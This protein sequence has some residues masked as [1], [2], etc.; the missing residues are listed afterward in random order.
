MSQPTLQE[1]SR[2]MST[3]SPDPQDLS[4][5]GRVLVV[6]Q[7]P[8][9][10]APWMDHLREPA[11][12][13]TIVPPDRLFQAG[14]T[15]GQ[16]CMLIEPPWDPAA[17]ER[18]L[19]GAQD[20]GPMPLTLLDAALLDL[21]GARRQ[22][23]GA[24]VPANDCAD[25]LSQEEEPSAQTILARHLKQ[26]LSAMLRL[27]TMIDEWTRR[28]AVLSAF[29]M[30]PADAGPASRLL[31][32]EDRTILVAGEA[33]PAYARIE[34]LCAD[35]HTTVV[36]AFTP[37][38][39]V[40]YLARHRFDVLVL[41]A[42]KQLDAFL[43]VISAVRRNP[44]LSATPV[45]LIV[46]GTPSDPVAKAVKAGA[47]DVL[48]QTLNDSVFALRI[49]ALLMESTLRRL[50]KSALEACPPVAL[51]DTETG[52]AGGDLCTA[53]LERMVSEAHATRR[54]WSFA[55][56]DLSRA[57]GADD[58]AIPT[59]D[60]AFAEAASLIG[61]MAR[62]QDFRA[63]IGPRELALVLPD[64]GGDAAQVVGQRVGGA[65][66]A[67]R[68]GASASESGTGGDG[69]VIMARHTVVSPPLG[70]NATGLLSEAR[71]R[72]AVL[73]GASLVPGP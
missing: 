65:L 24:P 53:Q 4:C 63:R 35:R 32:G 48:P 15:A 71:A 55:L 19:S 45:I 6:R 60:H 9:Q 30:A 17:I 41:T 1:T 29:N 34:A 31:E 46:D 62:A 3:P 10:A 51:R 27:R 47:T 49:R 33:G 38:T 54:A 12:D 36:G 7:E 11:H 5:R 64:T 40:D 22:T 23:T 37:V 2:P 42:A 13:R 52:L 68:F 20:G 61:A 57:R 70:M 14:R 58:V 16:D 73:S 72:L 21:A 39:A 43:P 69:V 28:H 26:R 8:D 59:P 44:R 18:L 67:A 56:L 50:L 25:H 66:A